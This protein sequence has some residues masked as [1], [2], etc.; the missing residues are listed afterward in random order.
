MFPPQS[1]AHTVSDDTEASLLPNAEVYHAVAFPSLQHTP[2]AT[3]TQVT[4]RESRSSTKS[5]TWPTQNQITNSDAAPSPTEVTPTATTSPIR[6]NGA[7]QSAPEPVPRPMLSRSR[8]RPDHLRMSQPVPAFTQFPHPATSLPPTGAVPVMIRTSAPLPVMEPTPPS[9][10]TPFVMFQPP[11]LPG[12]DKMEKLPSF[13]EFLQM[14][15]LVDERSSDELGRRANIAPSRRF[16]SVAL[17]A[18]GARISSD[19]K[20]PIHPEKC[21]GHRGSSSYQNGRVTNPVQENSNAYAKSCH[22]DSGR[23]VPGCVV[24]ILRHKHENGSFSFLA[25]FSESWL[26]WVT[27]RHIVT[28]GEPV[29]PVWLQYVTKEGLFRDDAFLNEYRRLIS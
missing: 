2:V 12:G 3:F 7:P 27:T 6:N 25:R 9:H 1:P 29:D 28:A 22:V 21:T 17:D 15:G 11:R 18:D 14:A 24:A 26:S 5:T 8:S 23:F 13:G 16:A 4:N 19:T 20:R 10:Y